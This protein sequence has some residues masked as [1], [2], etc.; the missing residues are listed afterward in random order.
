[1]NTRKYGNIFLNPSSSGSQK[2]VLFDI[3]YFVGYKDSIE[4][5]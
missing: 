1:M 3:E 4:N 5:K 2:L